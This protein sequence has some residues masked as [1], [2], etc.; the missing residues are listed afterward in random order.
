MKL[1]TDK[2]RAAMRSEAD[3]L[4]AI[5]EESHAELASMVSMANNRLLILPDTII[6]CIAVAATEATL[7]IDDKAKAGT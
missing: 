1:L 6:A 5:L 4:W 7:R 3:K 2:D